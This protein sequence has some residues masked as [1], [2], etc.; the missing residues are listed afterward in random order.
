MSANARFNGVEGL[1]CIFT[2]LPANHATP[3]GIHPQGHR[4]CKRPGQRDVLM[5]I[6]NTLCQT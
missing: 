5:N 1:G 6:P 4:Y 2:A 3:E